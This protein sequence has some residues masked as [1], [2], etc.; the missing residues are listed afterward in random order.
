MELNSTFGT[1]LR[2]IGYNLY[3]A[4]ARVN[5]SQTTQSFGPFDHML[6]IVTIGQDRY[7]VD[8]GFGSNYV[9]TLP[10][11]L[12]NDN[13]GFEN[14]NPAR[15][16]LVYKSIEGAR[17]PLSKLW[18]YQHRVGEEGEWKDMYCFHAELEFRERDFEM[19]N[20]WTSTSCKTI[21]TQRVICNKM[22]A[23]PD[24]KDG[25]RSIVG[26]LGLGREVKRRVGSESEV[27]KE[28]ESEEE[29][30]KAL[31]EHFGIVLSE[32]EREA[33]RGTGDEIH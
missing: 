7:L 32:V 3:H 29:R 10:V 22:I 23:S 28:F 1:L 17:N 6:N 5:S 4:G 26:T 24:E 16:R 18:V 2:S 9:P 33:I 19:M 25:E 20:W 12:I 27:L 15:G 8:V 13:A 30:V 14:V 21:F 11:R 31:R